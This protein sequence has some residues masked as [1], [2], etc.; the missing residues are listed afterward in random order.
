[1]VLDQ[2]KLDFT[3]AQVRMKFL[4]DQKGR[5]GSSSKL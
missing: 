2:F 5:E 4:V 1:M 3:E